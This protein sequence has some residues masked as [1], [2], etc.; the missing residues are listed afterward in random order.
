VTLSGEERRSE[1]HELTQNR[2]IVFKPSRLPLGVPGV[3]IER[4]FDR[5]VQEHPHIVRVSTSEGEYRHT[6]ACEPDVN[7]VQ[8]V[9]KVT[10][11]RR[12]VQKREHVVAVQEVK[13]YKCCCQIRLWPVL[14]KSREGFRSG[15]PFIVEFPLE[16]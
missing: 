3:F 5:L 4:S 10:R 7:I 14:K 6:S 12:S 15:F 13:I 2:E 11:K 16:T 9:R 8:P 1:N